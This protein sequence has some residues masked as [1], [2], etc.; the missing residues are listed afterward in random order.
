MAKGLPDNIHLQVCEFSDLTGWPADRHDEAF[1]AFLSSA[2]RMLESPYK[3]RAL[4]IDSHALCKVAGAAVDLAKDGLPDAATAKAFF[5]THFKPHHII[6]DGS[7]AGFLTGFYEP[8]VEASPVQT[9]EFSVPL[10]RRPDDLVDVDDDNRPSTMDPYFRFGRNANGQ[11]EE[12]F[13][14]SQVQQG[15]LE[16][17]GLEL[18]WLRNKVEAFFIHVQGSAKLQ[19]PDGTA[20]R[21]TYAAKSG[22]PY[23]SVAKV[24][25]ARH[26]IDPASMTADRLAQ[27]MHSHPD[28]LDDLLAHNDSYIYFKPIT[29]LDPHAGPIAA[30]KVPLI[31]GRSMAVDR[32]LHTFG[33]PI[34]LETSQP[35]PEDSTPLARLMIAHDTGSAI[36]GANR[37]DY[38]A[39]SGDDAG[40]IGGRIRHEARMTVLVP[41]AVMMGG[42]S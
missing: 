25:C 38:F 24:L 6:V 28:E 26:Q 8:V 20:M 34:W 19:L 7:K 29:G 10:Y 13:T 41:N 33:S 30:A 18:V 36:V 40:R 4:G 23:T 22:H 31:A 32:L 12:H 9:T 39:G 14:R 15:A 21:V 17:Q 35:L 1:A 42:S 3:T 11:I 27:W 16:G 2:R 5:Q 37:G